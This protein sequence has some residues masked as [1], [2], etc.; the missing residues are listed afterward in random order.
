MAAQGFELSGRIYHATSQDSVALPARTVVLHEVD[1]TGGAAIDSTDTD[2]AGWY[3]FFV[4][5]PDTT[6]EYFVS[7]EQADIGYFSR[8]LRL[9][10]VGSDTAPPIVVYDTSYASPRISLRER[11]VIVRSA[12]EDG[13]RQFVELI[14]LSNSGHLTR[15]PAD[16]ANP[17]WQGSLPAGAFGLTVG[18][19]EV[20][21]GAVYRRGSALAVAAPIPPGDKRFLI[22]YIVPRAGGV[23]EVPVGQATPRLT[24][25][26]E[27]TTGTVD[28]GGLAFYGIET[29]GG[30]YFKRYD[31]LEVPAS[32]T[33]YVR[34]S[35]PFFSIDRLQLV[36]V[37]I[38][39]LGM[40]GT[41]LWWIRRQRLV[42]A[43]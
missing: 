21:R 37:L 18:E 3:R 24:V 40:A 32:T 9:A 30:S 16:T 2:Q 13:T 7:V 6:A 27:D 23:L 41:L 19:S 14:T 10:A 33:V 26:L 38:V 43:P 31:A 42:S 1:D 35:Q 4:A 36:V 8:V 25:S 20:G 15:I 39:A 28:G 22:S 29:V 34:I 17:V 12:E 5:E 11:H